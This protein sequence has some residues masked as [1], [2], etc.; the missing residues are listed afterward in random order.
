MGVGISLECTQQVHHNC[1][2]QGCRCRCHYQAKE[3]INER[4]QTTFF[5]DSTEDA[6]TGGSAP[7]Q[8]QNGTKVCPECGTVRPKREAYCRKDG[9]KLTEPGYC[10]NCSAVL[11]PDDV[12]C[13]ACGRN[14][15]ED[16][17]ETISGIAERTAT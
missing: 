1:K 3:L 9:A 14:L 10:S 6:A 15:G 13:W 17:R 7:S 12:Y 2:E 8:N 11:L 16:K 4:K 5:P